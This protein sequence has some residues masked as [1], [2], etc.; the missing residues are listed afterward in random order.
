MKHYLTKKPK[1][2]SLLHIRLSS[3]ERGELKCLRNFYLFQRKMLERYVIY[4]V[5]SEELVSELYLDV[6]YC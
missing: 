5:K 3:S 4:Q 6:T 1:F 2:N